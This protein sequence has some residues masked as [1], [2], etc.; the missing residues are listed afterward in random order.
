MV[1]G[2]GG[3]QGKWL[4]TIIFLVHINSHITNCTVFQHPV[5][6][7]PVALAQ[8]PKPLA[9]GFKPS[10]APKERHSLD[11]APEALL[12]GTAVERLVQVRSLAQNLAMLND[13][14]QFDPVST[15]KGKCRPWSGNQRGQWA[16]CYAERARQ[17]NYNLST[18]PHHHHSEVFLLLWGDGGC[19]EP[20]HSLNRKNQASC[21]IHFP[22]SRHCGDTPQHTLQIRNDDHAGSSKILLYCP[23]IVG[24][25]FGS[26]Y[27]PPHQILQPTNHCST[28][29]YLPRS[30]YCTLSQTQNN[31]FTSLVRTSLSIPQVPTRWQL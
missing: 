11:C 27:R 1:S 29:H 30:R 18:Y 5:F 3:G 17:S 24:Q 20:M 26:M 10:R 13:T 6:D 4:L 12:R 22:L 16:G 2:S 14:D 9:A 23:Y 31:T 28:I 19:L 15:S 21:Q 7:S 8:G 25:I